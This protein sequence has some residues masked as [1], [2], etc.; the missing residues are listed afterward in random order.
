MMNHP[1][2]LHPARYVFHGHASGVS[3]HIRRPEDQVL[4]VQSM[5]ALPTI[6]GHAEHNVGRTDLGKWVSFES[7]S[8]SAHGDYVDAKQGVA[9]TLG[10]LEFSAAA[11]ETK[12]TARVRGL[13]ILGRLHIADQSM[14]LISRSAHGTAQPPFRHESTFINGVRID[15]SKLKIELGEKFFTAHD[16]KDKLK[17][18][19]EK[20]LPEEHS[21]MYLPHRVGDEVVTKFPEAGNGMVK[22]TIVQSLEWDGAPHPEAKIHGHVVVVPNFGK[23]YFGEMYVTADARRLTLVRCQLGS[24]T[25]GEVSSGDGQSNGSGF[26]PA[27]GG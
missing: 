25:G 8:T 4:T 23:I 3:A 13:S 5:S 27:G 14:C 20:G 26:P 1:K 7:A 21:R 12:V 22:F 6:G 2:H 11:T 15:D 19:F 18:A 9:T 10:E 17:A 16:T 24:D